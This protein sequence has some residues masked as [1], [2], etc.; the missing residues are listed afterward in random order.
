MKDSCDTRFCAKCFAHWL[1][2]AGGSALDQPCIKLGSRKH[3]GIRVSRYQ[4]GLVITLGDVSFPQRIMNPVIHEFI[5]SRPGGFAELAVAA[6]KKGAQD[7]G[8]LS[9][10][11]SS[12][13]QW[14]FV[15]MVIQY[16][17]LAAAFFS[18]LTYIH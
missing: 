8:F 6:S 11:V 2:T 16:L 18:P 9:K 5:Q 15:F 10:T 1:A 4:H 3:R 17:T 13:V 14:M 12:W 7:V